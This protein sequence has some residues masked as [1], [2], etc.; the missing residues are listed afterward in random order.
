MVTTFTYK[1]SL[2]RI[3]A[4]NVE[5]LWYQT[6]PQTNTQTHRQGLLQYAAP[7]PVRSVMTPLSRSKGQ[8][9]GVGAYRPTAQLD[10]D[11]ML[12]VHGVMESGYVAHSGSF[13]KLPRTVKYI[14]SPL[15]KPHARI[16]FLVGCRKRQLNQGSYSP[17]HIVRTM[18]QRSYGLRPRYD[19]TYSQN[20]SQT[21]IVA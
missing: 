2:V 3:G 18:E 21:V 11:L 4:C 17:K 1:P 5:L 16:D 8:L 13:H 12:L 10:S 20:V 7:Q 6:H 19:T 9:A 14:R 15:W